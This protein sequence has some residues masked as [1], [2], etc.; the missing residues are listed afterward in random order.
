VQVDKQLHAAR[1]LPQHCK[2]PYCYF[3]TFPKQPAT[4]G[5]HSPLS[6]RL[7][8]DVKGLPASFVA[9]LQ[10]AGVITG[11]SAVHHTVLAPDGTSK[12]LLQLGEGRLI[13]AVG[14][15][16]QD[17]SKERLT[18]CVSSQV[19]QI[20]VFRLVNQGYMWVTIF[21]GF[22]HPRM[23]TLSRRH[24]ATHTSTITCASRP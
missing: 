15:P 10:A 1:F 11:R 19:W 13:E 18:V 4:L 12:M 17:G 6:T 20:G 22:S 24:H 23:F 8:A 5:L 21:N 14:I 9:Q 2:A 7:P 3:D 16:T